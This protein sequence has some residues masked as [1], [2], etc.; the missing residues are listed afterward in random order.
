MAFLTGLNGTA[1]LVLLSAL[2]FAEE[3]GIPLP[4]L[5]G[6]VLL[7]AAGLLIT[8]EAI[9]PFI[10]FPL[11]YIA[12]VA[13]ALA[14]YAWARV[15]GAKGLWALA[16]RLHVTSHLDRAMERLRTAGPVEIA[17]SRLIP[18]LRIYTTLVA[19]AAEVDL[20][21]FLLG[22]LPAIALWLGLFTVAG[23]LIG[24]PLVH[25][26]TRVEHLALTAVV[27][28]LIGMGAFL[29]ILHI[30][31]PE[32]RDNALVEAPRLPRLLLALAI[33][34][35]MV[36]N[37]D[38]G[39]TE[40]AHVFLHFPNPD[41]IIDVAVVFATVAVAYFGIVRHGWGVTAGEAFLNIDY[42]Y[43]R[44]R[45]GGNEEPPGEAPEVKRISAHNDVM[46]EDTPAERP[47][48]L[49]SARPAR[50]RTRRSIEVQ[51]ENDDD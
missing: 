11:A 37:I 2:L 51:D 4:F 49:V 32:R 15:I 6:E 31:V 27:L 25:F 20:R 28:T 48:S 42:N 45:G 10:F 43:R 38:F 22:A 9:S 29:A 7:V 36:T 8:N 33:D 16:E 3:A 44:S 46:H 14:G 19:G 30:P 35:G 26:L 17:I 40:L 39:L 24:I 23:M 21:T 34:G 1:A 41:G 47:D 5:P 12:V 18:G 50:V 13:G